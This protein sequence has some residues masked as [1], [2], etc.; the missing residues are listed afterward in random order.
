[1]PAYN[2]EKYVESAVRSIWSMDYRPIELIVLN[3]GSTDSTLSVLRR[4]EMDSPIEMLVIEKKN[5]GICKTLNRGVALAR[6]KYITFLAS[7]DEFVP[8]R[9]TAHIKFLESVADSEVA[10]CYGQRQVIDEHGNVRIEILKQQMVY[11]DLFVALLECKLPFSLQGSTFRTNIVK[12]LE[13]DESLF[14]EDWDFFIRLTLKHKFLY[15]PGIAFRY[16]GHEA[17]MNRNMERMAN[18]RMDVF[19][20]HKSH[21]RVLE[22]GAH[23]FKSYIESINAQ[24]FFLIGDFLNVRKWLLQS[25]MSWPVQFFLSV[26]LAIKLMMGARAVKLA[27]SVKRAFH[28]KLFV[29]S[30]H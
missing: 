14:F 26:P 3:D 30:A 16:R 7:D 5:E 18:A 9:M 21:P 6:G 24:G 13:F 17:G 12:A 29:K 4:L 22:Y 15:F 28:S 1:M 11:P 8:E 2:H 27:R 19:K 20:K 10:G 23:K 25:W